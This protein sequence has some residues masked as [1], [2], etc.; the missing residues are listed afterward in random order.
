MNLLRFLKLG[1]VTAFFGL[2]LNSCSDFLTVDSENKTVTEGY[3]DS[4]KKVEQAVVGAYV[5][6]RRALLENHA[7]LM[8]GEVRAGDLIVSADCF[9]YV[10]GQDLTANNDNLKQLTDWEYFYDVISNANDV[11]QVVEQV[12]NNVL[13]D[14]QYKL[15]KGEALAIKSIGYFYLARIWGNVPS[16]EKSDFGTLLGNNAAVERSIAFA[17][18]A[19]QLLPWML[20]NDDGIESAALTAIR[21][22]KTAITLLL[23]QENLWLRKKEETYTLLKATFTESAKDSLSGFGLSMGKDERSNIPTRPLDGS[24]V[25]ISL[26]KLN[27]I[28]PKGDK[29]RGSMY[30][31]SEQKGSATLV[32]KDG[33]ILPLLAVN[34]LYLLQAEAAWGVGNLPEAISY[35]SSAATGSVEDYSTLTNDT[36]EDALMLERQRLLMGTGQRFFDLMRFGKVNR[37]IPFYS[38]NDVAS[39]AGYWPISVNSLVGNSLVQN[40]YWAK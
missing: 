34:E 6:L 32:V 4:P 37:T 17:R 35:L 38:E 30:D 28:Y 18:Q 25:T 11:L 27:S 39:G 22:N 23:A 2:M 13:S 3:Y 36:F 7:W 12:K 31:I 20:V 14:Y 5:N 8:Y 21:F 1:L 10:A 19:Q 33:T 29:R 24:I 9:K 40:S 16:A 26:D 15:Y